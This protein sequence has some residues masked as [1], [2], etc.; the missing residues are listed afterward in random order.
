MTAFLALLGLLAACAPAQTVRSV[1]AVPFVPAYLGSVS[2]ALAGDSFYGSRLL[3]AFHA[4]LS[5][6]AASPT[7]REAA[8]GLAARIAGAEGLPLPKVAEG[9]GRAPVSPERAAAILAANALAR[10]D[11]FREVVS[12]LETMKPGLGDR[13]VEAL[14]GAPSGHPELSA[15]LRELGR[16]VVPRADGLLYDSAGALRRLF[17]GR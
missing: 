11:Q 10:P 5:A 7:P 4:E 3:N 14:R 13:V 17:D 15:R 12:G 2:M 6:V 8:Q 16:R 1:P 9:L